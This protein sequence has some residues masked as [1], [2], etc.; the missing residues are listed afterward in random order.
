MAKFHVS[1]DGNPR[2][3]KASKGNCPLAADINHY[4]TP[5][6]A[7]AGYEKL[8]KFRAN[9]GITRSTQDTRMAKLPEVKGIKYEPE[10]NGEGASD[11]G[12]KYSSIEAFRE[13]KDGSRARIASITVYDDGTAI[14][15]DRTDANEADIK[16]RGRLLEPL[17][18]SLEISPYSSPIF[19]L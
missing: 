6:E 12:I 4:E 1:A 19:R 9:R 3:C 11:A 7:R 8:Q 2:A 13:R 16:A 5:E 14:V 18:E 10:S 17:K 15:W